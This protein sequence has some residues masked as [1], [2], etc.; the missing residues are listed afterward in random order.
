MSWKIDKKVIIILF[1]ALLVRGLFFIAFWHNG[2]FSQDEIVVSDAATY[3]AL[4]VSLVERGRFSSDADGILLD[5]SA[6]PTYP[7]FIGVIYFLFGIKPWL[8]LLFQVFLDVATCLLIYFL[9]MILFH[10]K[11]IAFA[12]GLLYS[13]EPISAVFV[14]HLM[15][16]ICF[17]F[18]FVLSLLI[19]FLAI[20]KQRMALFAFSGI[21]LGIAVLTRPVALYFFVIV[22]L[23]IILFSK[24]K[25]SHKLKIV[26]IFI[27]MLELTLL[28]WQL[29][30][31]INFGSLA[32]TSM[33]GHN[34]LDYNAAITE[35]YLSRISVEEARAKFEKLIPSGGLLNYMEMS[36]IKQKI[37]L[38]YI[39]Q[40]PMDYSLLHLKGI[41]NMFI[42]S[43]KYETM[44]I[45]GLERKTPRDEDK[46]PLSNNIINRLRQPIVNASKEYY[47]IFPLSFLVF[48][49]YVFALVGLI[50]LFVKKHWKL[51]VTFIVI[52]A[53][54]SLITGIIGEARYKL[55][56]IPVYLMLS[57]YG[58][59][60]LADFFRCKK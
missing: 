36:R 8:V 59:T 52:I 27:I 14:L 47:L 33:Q 38:N 56:I 23:I 46:V 53:Y 3:H 55:P 34:L 43:V 42:N 45:F 15:T 20:K 54:Y 4:A 37:A 12:G 29:R 44:K 30:N 51:A 9:A 11:K 41:F 10:N 49:E 32:I 18:F 13:I 24:N 48:L 17:V 35:A 19:L 7:L 31:F 6:T 1:I 60:I 57:G 26:T 22:S 58:I 5:T 40:H 2:G 21:A 28:P 50:G 16:E 39:R 25:V